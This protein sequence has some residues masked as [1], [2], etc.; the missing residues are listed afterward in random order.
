MLGVSPLRLPNRR[1]VRFR[2]EGLKEPAC[3]V[4]Y[5]SGDTVTNGMPLGVVD[6]GCIDLETSG[7][8]GY[9][10]IFNTHVPRRGPMNV[11]L[12]GLSIGGQ[13]WLLCEPIPLRG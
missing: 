9:S 12:L 13:T 3:E 5:R 10:T 2:A 1:W 6:T 11:P 7:M 4:V 8:L